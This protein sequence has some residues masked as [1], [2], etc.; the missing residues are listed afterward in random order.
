MDENFCS[1]EHVRRL[2]AL[3][4]LSRKV[5]CVKRTVDGMVA[6]TRASKD[7]LG[8]HWESYVLDE[9]NFLRILMR[10]R[11][12]LVACIQTVNAERGTQRIKTD[13]D[14]EVA[15]LL[16]D[17]PCLATRMDDS[18]AKAEKTTARA[19]TACC[20]WNVSM[21]SLWDSPSRKDDAS[22]KTNGCEKASKLALRMER[23]ERLVEGLG[24]DAPLLF[25]SVLSDGKDLLWLLMTGKDE[26]SAFVKLTGKCAKTSAAEEVSMLAESVKH[27]ARI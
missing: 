22:Q 5:E 20:W 13:A 10:R 15:A 1:A 12:T 27:P 23:L 4:H 11:E 9:R 17:Y 21:G 2:D 8:V 25:R 26:A 7:L 24:L 14:K 16:R 3:N 18:K 6:L 19:P